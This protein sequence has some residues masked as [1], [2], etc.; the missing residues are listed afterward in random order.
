MGLF[1]GNCCLV[2]SMSVIRL[3]NT[4]EGEVDGVIHGEGGGEDED[5]PHPGVLLEDSGEESPSGLGVGVG[6]ESGNDLGCPF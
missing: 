5:L 6:V 1:L 4:D 3:I 2:G